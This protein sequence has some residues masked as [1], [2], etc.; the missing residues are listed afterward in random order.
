V[1]CPY[2]GSTM[3][4][5]MRVGPS[6]G[7]PDGWHCG[8]CPKGADHETRVVQQMTADLKL[9]GWNSPCGIDRATGKPLTMGEMYDHY[10]RCL[11]VIREVEA[12]AT[13]S[14]CGT[15]SSEK[16]P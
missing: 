11:W 16:K 3:Q 15:P 9:R 2:C 10:T 1:R 6:P 13:T 14:A 8:A 4:A 12:R 7:Q 5:T